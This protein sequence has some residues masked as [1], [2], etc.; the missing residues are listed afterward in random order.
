VGP[1]VR[2]LHG[3][4]QARVP[5]PWLDGKSLYD[6]F[7]GEGVT[8]SAACRPSGKACCARRGQRP[9]VQHDARTVIGGS[10]CPPAMM[11]AFQQRYDVQVLHAWGMTEMSRLG[12]VCT[13]EASTEH[14]CRGAL[15][16]RPSRG[17]PSIGVDMKIVGDDG[18]ELPPTAA[19]RR[20]DG[21][22]ALD[23]RSYFKGGGGDPL[24][25]G[26]F[27]TGDV[28][29]STPTAYADH[30]PQQGRE[31]SPAANGSARSTREHSRWRTR[32]GNGRLHRRRASEVGRA[33]LWW[34]E[35]AG[36]DVTAR[37]S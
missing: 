13:L 9:E 30:G 17:V 7:E 35:E 15:R 10:A 16:C 25:D 21:A 20:A 14:E 37:A 24:V 18:Q 29:T 23:H 27:P 8:M 32:G 31:S 33:P 5:R 1:A 2:R 6:L 22:R 11:R 12:T 26:W 3:R 36:A 4:R 19:L 28:R 34:C